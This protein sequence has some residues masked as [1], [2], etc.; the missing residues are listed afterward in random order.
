[1]KSYFST[2]SRSPRRI[3]TRCFLAGLWLQAA[4]SF[5]MVPP[6]FV[7]DYRSAD[8][9]IELSLSENGVRRMAV[10]G[11]TLAPERISSEIERTGYSVFPYVSLRY[12]SPDGRILRL[13]GFLALDARGTRSLI[14]YLLAERIE[15]DETVTIL[16]LRRIQLNQFPPPTRKP[17][18]P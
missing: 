3:L 10:D 15:H 13:N 4:A 1:M 8:H 6:S 17:G 7:G 16:K 5:A 11:E 2:S 12:Q 9:A 18:R 14:G